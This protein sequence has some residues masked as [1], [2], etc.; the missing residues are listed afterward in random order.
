MKVINIH[1]EDEE[2]KE[3]LKAKGKDNWH[4]FILEKVF[5]DKPEII[6]KLKIKRRNE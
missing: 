1:F 6:S 3:L 2:F 5:E 4:N